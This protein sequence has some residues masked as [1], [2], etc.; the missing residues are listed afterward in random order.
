MTPKR[1]F[2]LIETMVAIA[3][4]AIIV[5]GILSAF[6]AITLAAN[7]HQQETT[8]DRLTRSEAEY[9]K[10]QV[11]SPGPPPAGNTTVYQNIPA[12]SGYTFAY[13]VL[14]Y[15]ALTNP[16]NFNAGNPD[17]GLQKITLT[18]RGPNGSSEVLIFMKEQP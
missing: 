6:S 2:S 9:I 17:V 13:Q 1:G 16:P 7:R 8:L 11:Y 15:S 4:M 14:Y 10:S 3:L 12:V 5:I 18:V